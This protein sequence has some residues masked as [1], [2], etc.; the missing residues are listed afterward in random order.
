MLH[1]IQRVSTSPGTE[2]QP[3]PDPG[4]LALARVGAAL[5][6]AARWIVLPSLALTALAVC[7][8][9]ANVQATH[10][11]R[12]AFA[13]AAGAGLF[14]LYLAFRIEFD[15]VVFQHFGGASAAG[16]AAAFDRAMVALGLTRAGCAD[17]TMADRVRGLVR[18][19]KHA[20][21]ILL[22]QGALLM[23]GYLA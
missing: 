1:G 4:G 9:V 14:Q 20:A 3:Q 18:L 23:V 2:E 22:L 8:L 15:R 12:L 13:A 6:V 17:R 19:V 5:G 7:S 11:A 21:F 10:V 16:A